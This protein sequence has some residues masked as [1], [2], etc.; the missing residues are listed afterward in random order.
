MPTVWELQGAAGKA[1]PGIILFIRGQG[2]RQALPADE[3]PGLHVAPVHGIPSD[4][5]GIVLEEQMVLALIEGKAVG[6]VYPAHAAREMV[7]G[8]QV[9]IYL[10]DMLRLKSP[11]PEQQ[12]TFHPAHRCRLSRPGT[13]RR[14]SNLKARSIRRPRPRPC[15]A[16]GRLPGSGS[17]GVLR[18][19]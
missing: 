1:A 6:V 9:R 19:N 15:A 11:G 18:R 17:S 14:K 13:A 10:R 16:P 7:M 4:V 5:I 2:Q 3:I 12:I 8:Q